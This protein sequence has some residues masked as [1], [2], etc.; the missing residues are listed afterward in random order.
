MGDKI[1]SFS[2]SNKEL[3]LTSQRHERSLEELEREALKIG[4]FEGRTE[5]LSRCYLDMQNEFN[6]L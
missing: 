1:E 5:R 4:G 6:K 3:S 2:S